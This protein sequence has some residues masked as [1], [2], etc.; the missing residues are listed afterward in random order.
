[1]ERI[2]E[3]LKYKIVAKHIENP[4]FLIVFVRSGSTALFRAIS[5]HSEVL[6]GRKES[7]MVEHFGKLIYDYY[8][9]PKE[10]AIKQYRVRAL[11]FDDY[12]TTQKFK[13]LI[14]E[15]ATHDNYIKKFKEARSQRKWIV[16]TFC[17]L[18]IVK[19][20]EKVFK[21]PK[22]I[23]IHRNGIDQIN[24]ALKYF[25]Y[26]D[27]DFQKACHDWNNTANVYEGLLSYKNCFSISHKDLVSEPKNLMSELLSFLD[28]PPEEN[29][30]NYI[31]ESIIHPQ[32][33]DDADGNYSQFLKNR[34]KIVW[35]DEQKTFFID[36]CEKNMKVYGYES[37]I[38]QLKNE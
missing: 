10:E 20:L 4:I 6:M 33:N 11:P 30:F 36:L 26:L 35:T 38:E 29:C 7:P 14:Y 18:E 21:N 34:K 37:E 31:S 22:F 13:S 5:Q 28:L 9:S 27:N 12:T 2:I 24:S 3:R 32:G 15:F 16:G 8:Y 23:F 19:G 1:M 25:T 17:N